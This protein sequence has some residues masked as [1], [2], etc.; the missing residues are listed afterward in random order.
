[1][2]V[3]SPYILYVNT[4]AYD[5]RKVSSIT[6]NNDDPTL[7]N[8]R[9]I[10]EARTVVAFDAVTFIAAWQAALNASAGSGKVLAITVADINNPTE[11]GAV[12]GSAANRFIIAVQTV[13]GND[14][15]TIYEWDTTG[16]VVNSPYVVAS[17]GGAWVAIGGRFTTS[18]VSFGASVKCKQVALLDG[19][20]IAT[21]CSLGNVFT[22]TL[23]G[24]R[25][26]ANPSNKAIGAVYVWEITQNGAGGHTLAFDTDFTWPAA[27]PP[28]ISAGIGAVD[29]ITGY[30]DGTKLRCTFIQAFA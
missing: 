8:V 18:Q 29:I 2:P 25:T 12:I 26:L 1:M 10:D 13:A 15:S 7:V 5:L 23:A 14:I 11:I 19:P 21:D 3:T 20:S 6:V 4:S 17:T 30:Y 22:V 28:I 9:F 27:T 16:A 24:D